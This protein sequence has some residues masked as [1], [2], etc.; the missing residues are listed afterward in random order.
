[1]Q[2]ILC[3]VFMLLVK[4]EMGG[5][6]TGE[7]QELHKVPVYALK[8]RKNAATLLRYSDWRGNCSSRTDLAP[9]IT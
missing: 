2:V 9:V 5:E 8:H 4:A 1:M 3:D 7:H 6:V